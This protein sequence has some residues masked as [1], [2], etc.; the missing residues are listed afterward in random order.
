L[1]FPVDINLKNL[2]KL[3]SHATIAAVDGQKLITVAV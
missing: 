1:A 2:S 3:V